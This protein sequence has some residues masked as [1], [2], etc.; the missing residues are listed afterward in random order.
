MHVCFQHTPAGKALQEA[1]DG[2]LKKVDIGKL[3]S[4]YLK[5]V[6]APAK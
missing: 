3:E 4:A 6:D 2:G 1:F 5:K